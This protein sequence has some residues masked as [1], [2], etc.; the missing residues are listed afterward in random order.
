[1]RILKV[2]SAKLPNLQNTEWDGIVGLLPTAT[3]GSQLLVEQMKAQGY[4]K[5][6]AF[7]VHYIDS[8]YG[9]EITFGGFD[10]SLVESIDNFTFTKLYD[11]NYWSVRLRGIKYGDIEI[12]GHAERGILDTGT[13]LLMLPEQDYNRWFTEITRNK[14]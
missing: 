11:N 4:I 13:S 1:M 6:A 7:S 10:D 9:S 14:T 3:G 5:N 12:G 2:E 8:K